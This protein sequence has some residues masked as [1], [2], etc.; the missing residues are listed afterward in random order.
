MDPTSSLRRF[1][2]TAHR[3]LVERS[4]RSLNLPVFEN[5]L[6]VGAGHDPYRYLFRETKRYVCLDIKPVRGVTNIIANALALPF[7]TDCFGCLIASEVLEHLSDPVLFVREVTRVLKPDGMAILTFPFLFHRHADPYDFWRFTDQGIHELFK[8]F[9]EI[10]VRPLGNN[11][12]VISDLLTTAYSPYS[13][14]FPLRLLN[15]IFTLLP[16]NKIRR[17]STSAPSGYLVVAR[18]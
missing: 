5:V 8:H 9:S 4:L 1:F 3:L 2:P 12:H 7:D 18:K 14:F 6:V 11:L 17:V 16:H 10:D 15:H 13:I